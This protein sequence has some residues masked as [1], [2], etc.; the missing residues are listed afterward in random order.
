MDFEARRILVYRIGNIGDTVV[1]LPALWAVRR[2]FPN[3]HIVLLCN[4]NKTSHRLAAEILPGQ[5]LIDEWLTY[6]SHDRGSSFLQVLGFLPNLRR[7]RLDTLVYLAPRLRSQKDVWR[8]LAY[9]R[10]AGLKTFI[11][12]KGLHSSLPRTTGNALKAVDHEADH[13]LERLS[14]CGIK[15][16]PY[17]KGEMNLALTEAEKLQG[18]D[19]IERAIPRKAD[20]QTLVGFGP[21]SKWPSKVWPEDRFGE[22]GAQ[23]IRE[24]DIQPVVFGGVDDVGLG[25]RLVNSW[26]R[27]VNGAGQ[28]SVRQSAAALEHCS[29][30]VGNDSG[31]MH[32]A[33]AVGVPCVVVMSAQDWPGRWHPYGE[34]HIVLRVAVPCEGCMLAVCNQNELRCLTEI[35]IEKVKQACIDTLWESEAAESYAFAKK[36]EAVTAQ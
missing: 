18:L 3:A 11:G 26:G 7:L 31:T 16:P 22:L 6:P 5:G 17:G 25:E 10:F 4:D 30:F 32:L 21:G 20:R 12:H 13:L 28:L 2:H 27:G 34:R 15:T 1:A 9:F 24:A 19:W 29:L 33:A 23:L 36:G 14:K 35:S 8:D